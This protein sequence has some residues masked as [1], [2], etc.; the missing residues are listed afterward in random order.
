MAQISVQGDRG[1]IYKWRKGSPFKVDAQVAG[2]HIAK[3]QEERGGVLT[4]DDVVDDAKDPSSPL[5]DEFEWDVEKA[6]AAHWRQRARGLMNHVVVVRTYS[7]DP[8]DDGLPAFI[9]VRVETQERGYVPLEYAIAD[10]DYRQSAIEQAW[11]LLQGLQRRFK[12]LSDPALDAIWA[13]IEKAEKH[14]TKKKKK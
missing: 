12:H 7:E 3:L 5:H 9:N 2:E 1:R 14:R 8:D 4:P 10:V 11:K 6:A 13:A